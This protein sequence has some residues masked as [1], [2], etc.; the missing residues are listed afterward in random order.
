MRAVMTVGPVEVKYPAGEDLRRDI[1]VRMEMGVR[2]PVWNAVSFYG[3]SHFHIPSEA[4]QQAAVE[5][6]CA[7]G[8]E[9]PLVGSWGRVFNVGLDDFSAKLGG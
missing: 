9:L 3:R 5:A 6:A 1:V 4:C 8:V 7:A 2:F